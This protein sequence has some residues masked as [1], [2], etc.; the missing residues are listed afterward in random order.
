[1]SDPAVAAFPTGIFLVLSALLAE[2]TSD[3]MYRQ[4]ASDTADFIHAHLY[5]SS[6]LVQDTISARRNDS[7]ELTGP[8]TD[9][10]F[11]GLVIEGLSILFSIT[12]KASTQVMINDLITVIPQTN[13]QQVDGILV[14]YR[15]FSP[16]DLIQGLRVAYL[17]NV[18]SPEVRD[19]MKAYIGVQFNALIDLATNATNIYAKAWEGP[20]S[21]TFD[22]GAQTD[23]IQ[24]L[25]SALSFEDVS[26]PSSPTP[27]SSGTILPSPSSS[28]K[29]S[30]TGS[31]VGGL[32]GG[33]ALLSS[34]IVVFW[35]VQR[36]RL[37]RTDASAALQV[38]AMVFT[39]Y[40]EGPFSRP[41]P[42]QRRKINT[43]AVSPP[44]SGDQLD[45]AAPWEE[46]M[47]TH[48]THPRRANSD[49]QS[50]EIPTAQLVEMLHQRFQ[51]EDQPP[52]YPTS[53]LSP[54]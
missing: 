37:R 2:A 12:K 20:P 25:L 40:T 9:P 30:M 50:L 1:M 13:W 39:P 32:I 27:S 22:G 21:L 43:G 35:R 28:G 19:W 23:A 29:S 11:S 31:I 17:R 26:P 4:A 47:H 41:L 7:C 33:L 48:S 54:Q 15:E 14:N 45:G 34:M 6:H 49:V 44:T 18:T 5:T 51:N 8:G 16:R 38:E 52:E 3:P 42:S 46:E 10:A 36:W 53:R 24:V